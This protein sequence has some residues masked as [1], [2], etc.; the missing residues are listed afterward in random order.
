MV[1]RGLDGAIWTWRCACV[2]A[3]TCNE[4]EYQAV[5]CG[6]ELVIARYPGARVRCLSDSLVVVEQIS[7]RCQVRANSLQPLQQRATYLAGQ[8]TGVSFVH[9]PREYNRLADALAWEALAGPRGLVD[10]TE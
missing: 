6:L 4:A 7:G 8:L 9:I 1:V 3:R 2:P 10:R 5:I